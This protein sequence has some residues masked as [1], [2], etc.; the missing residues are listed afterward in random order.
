LRVTY[1]LDGTALYGGVK[2]VFQHAQILRRMG[3][4]ARVVSPEP[5]P[6]WFP[7]TAEFHRH[8]PKLTPAAI[9]ATDIAVGTI[10]HTVP[11]ADSVPGARA[12]HLCQCWEA[13]YEPI[14]DEWEEIE[15]VYRR[16][17]IKMAVSSHL[18]QLIEARY[19]QPCALI[20]QPLQTDLFSPAPEPEGKFRVLISGRWDLD[21]KGVE[22]AM[23][24]LRDEDIELV[25]LTQTVFDD[26]RAFWPEA[27]YHAAIEPWKVP[28]VMRSVHA[29][30]SLSTEVEGFGLPTL[31][32]M[33]CGRPCVV[34]DNSAHRSMD[35]AGIATLRVPLND[36]DALRAA[37]RR[38]RDNPP[39]RAQ[40]G[41]EGR[42]IAET[43]SEERT[44]RALIAAFENA[45]RR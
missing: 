3:V 23:R 30:V 28:D 7:E 2:V 19:G 39:L 12:A 25:R 26:E 10:Y 34:S 38:L 43:Y 35:P 9:G 5:T 6:H 33:S 37:I 18:A 22:R 31:E 16:P 45:M 32:A 17:T 8:V 21:V 4:D 24:V 14:R 41:R 29:Y 42:K 27:E 44:G 20:P 13:A 11:I 40:L 1:V 36:D 15:A